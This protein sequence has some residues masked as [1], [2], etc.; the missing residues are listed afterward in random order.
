MLGLTPAI[1]Q[2]LGTDTP[3]RTRL[4]EIVNFWKSKKQFWVPPSEFVKSFQQVFNALVHV[5][6]LA[7]NADV[8]LERLF[9]DGAVRFVFQPAVVSYLW[10]WL[11]RDKGLHL[12]FP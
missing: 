9:P 7:C 10:C 11:L 12:P 3:A 2:L 4:M 6:D 8:V 5:R 1:P